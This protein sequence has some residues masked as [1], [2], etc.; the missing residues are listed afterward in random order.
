MLSLSAFIQV[1]TACRGG[2]T[3][4]SDR[5]KT[6]R[7]SALKGTE[8]EEALKCTSRASFLFGTWPLYTLP[9]PPPGRVL[10]NC[11]KLLLLLLL[12]Y[13]FYLRYHWS[14][15][16]PI[17]G[18]ADLILMFN[19]ELVIITLNLPTPV[20]WRLYINCLNKKVHCKDVGLLRAMALDLNYQQFCTLI[21]I[22]KSVQLVNQD[23]N[24]IEFM[25]LGAI[26][27]FLVSKYICKISVGFVCFVTIAWGQHGGVLFSTVPL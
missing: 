8:Q 21:S 7:E 10:L 13:T 12:S 1:V 18:S 3:V 23:F 15:S 27:V 2:A 25:L 6:S 26:C 16:L 11:P 17:S 20:C 19:L 5:G 24:K 9:V 14:W 22:S 4:R